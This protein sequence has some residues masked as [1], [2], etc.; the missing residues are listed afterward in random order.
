MLRSINKRSRYVL[1]STSFVCALI[2]LDTNVIAVSLPSISRSLGASFRELEWVIS[3]YVLTFATFLLFAGA[4]SDRYGRKRCLRWGLISFLIASVLCGYSNTIEMLNFG[5]ALKGIGAAF[6]LTGSLAIIGNEF[7]EEK[8]R[9]RAWGI[10][11][12]ILGLTITV[13]PILGGLITSYLGWRWAFY[14]NVPAVCILLWAIQKNVVESKDPYSRKLDFPGLITF[15]CSLFFFCWFMIDLSERSWNE[16][17]MLLR[18]GAS[19]LFLMSFLWVENKQKEPMIELTLF[20]EKKLL[21]A[22]CSML[23][24]ALTAQVLMNYI[25]LYLQNVFELDSLQAGFHMMPFAVAM[26]I[27]PRVSLYLQSHLS[28]GSVLTLGLLTVAV[29]NFLG[30]MFVTG[31]SYF[32]VACALAIMGA[33]AGMLN[34]ETTKSI[35]GSIVPHK[36]GMASG[37]STTTRF[38]G[39]LIGVTGLGSVLAT[40]TTRVFNENMQLAGLSNSVNEGFIKSLIAGDM[41]GQNESLKAA[42]RAA[43]SVGFSQVLLTASVLAF[44]IA[45]SVFLLMK[46]RTKKQCAMRIK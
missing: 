31:D 27:C 12:S 13:S 44:L 1:L 34:G 29:G 7:Q 23:G 39:I 36:S 28:Q 3:S 21:G 45:I 20:R 26:I 38:A 9:A 24:Y 18:M 5:R 2:M 8:D 40:T 42:G 37:I 15:S 41:T 43:F 35:M 10:W 33:G 6:L 30:S 19:I 32:Y 46:V 16:P 25:P 17:R 4:V 11:G 22:V 14:I